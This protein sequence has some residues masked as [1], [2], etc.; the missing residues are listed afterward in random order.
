MLKLLVHD[1]MLYIRKSGNG[2]EGGKLVESTPQRHASKIV[3][4]SRITLQWKSLTVNIEAC[5]CIA[6]RSVVDLAGQLAQLRLDIRVEK[7]S[8]QWNSYDDYDVH[9]SKKLVFHLAPLSSYSIIFHV[10]L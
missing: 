4:V 6:L 8:N 5:T 9:Q 2:F 1:S 10:R 3:R 7:W